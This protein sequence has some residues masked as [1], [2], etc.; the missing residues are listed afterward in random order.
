MA[1]ERLVKPIRHKC[2]VVLEKILT[3]LV[4]KETGVDVIIKYVEKEKLL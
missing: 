1:L 3:K 4:S 2:I